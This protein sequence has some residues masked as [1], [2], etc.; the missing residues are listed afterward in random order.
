ME[1]IIRTALQG[2][3]RDVSGYAGPLF[4]IDRNDLLVFLDEGSRARVTDLLSPMVASSCQVLAA[5]LPKGAKYIGFRY[6]AGDKNGMGDCLPHRDCLVR[7][8]KWIG[9]PVIDRTSGVTVV[10][11][12]FLNESKKR[13]RRAILTVYF[14]PPANWAPPG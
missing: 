4:D 9:N 13:Q 5:V 6:E 2:S 7:E 10:W 3:T 8:S 14:K 1:G 12:T 11:G